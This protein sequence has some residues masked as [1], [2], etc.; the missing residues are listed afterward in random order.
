MKYTP[1]SFVYLHDYARSWGYPFRCFVKRRIRNL[2][3][4]VCIQKVL[5]KIACHSHM[6]VLLNCNDHTNWLMTYWLLK[7]HMHSM[8]IVV[9]NAMKVHHSAHNNKY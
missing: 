3:N 5:A 7:I 9:N 1:N 4:R 8:S 2:A 6:Y